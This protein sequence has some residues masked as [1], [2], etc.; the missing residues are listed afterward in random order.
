MRVKPENSEC[1]VYSAEL[2]AVIEALHYLTS[3][4]SASAIIF[5]DCRRALDAIANAKLSGNTTQPVL[6]ILKKLHDFK[7]G[8][9]FI[10]IAWIN[11]HIGIK[12]NGKVDTLAKQATLLDD[13]IDQPIPAYDIRNTRQAKMKADWQAA[14][15]GNNTGM[16]YKSYCVRDGKKQWFQN[17]S[18][19]RKA[20]RQ[21]CRLRSNHAI[22]S[23]YL[24]RIG[25]VPIN[26]CS[27][28]GVR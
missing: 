8:N 23:S 27:V 25:K 10:R 15:D 9:K 7:M 6:D 20:I 24:H 3:V 12:E 21:L 13:F 5:T 22:C 19:S 2:F 17:L 1:S 4:N 18:L 16:F 11:G 26:M 28:C 14:Y